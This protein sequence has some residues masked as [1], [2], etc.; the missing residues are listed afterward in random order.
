MDTGEAV[1]SGL[2]EQGTNDCSTNAVG[3]DHPSPIQDD[4]ACVEAVCPST[5]PESY[6][7]ATVGTSV[8]GAGG[9][10]IG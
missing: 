4:C 3:I 6:A 1:P 10:L 5:P 8:D 2:S 9:T 7:S